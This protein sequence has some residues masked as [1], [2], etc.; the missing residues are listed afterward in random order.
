MLE[1][2][3]ILTVTSITWVGLLAIWAGASRRHWFLRAGVFVGVLSLLL[4]I[5]AYEPF[6]AFTLQGAVVAV[7]VK[8]HRWWVQRKEDKSALPRCL[9]YSVL[10]LLQLTVF[11]AI[12]M[13]VA[14]K[15]PVLNF[16][17][18]QSVVL[19]GLVSGSATLLGLWIAHGRLLRWWWRIALGVPLAILLS[20]PLVWWEWFVQQRLGIVGWPRVGAF[21]GLSGDGRQDYFTDWIPMIACVVGITS[22]V[23]WLLAGETAIGPKV[24]R[25]SGQIRSRPLRATACV[26]L[27]LVAILL[28]APPAYVY[29]RLMTPLPIPETVLPNPNGFDDLAAAGEMAQKWKYRDKADSY[30]VVPID[31]LTVAVKEMQP[32]FERLSIGL[33]RPVV[34]PV[35]YN[36]Y[37]YPA[38]ES[39]FNLRY[40]AKALDGQGRLAQREGRRD[41]ALKSFRDAIQLGY[42]FR[43]GGTFHEALTGVVISD[44]GRH[45]LY[46]LRGELATGQCVEVI[47][48]LNKYQEQTEPSEVIFYRTRV[49]WQHEREWY[50]YLYLI[51]EGMLNKPDR[52]PE[53]LHRVFTREIAKTQLL[54]TELAIQVWQMSHSTLPET[55]DDLVSNYLPEVPVDPFDPDGGPLRYRRT[56]DGYVLYSVSDNGKDDGG[57]P[58]DKDDDYWRIGKTGDLRLDILWAPEPEADEN[59][60]P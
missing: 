41:D 39:N 35:D 16:R 55:L 52:F 40:L 56:D 4:L 42:V 30:N 46:D 48:M 34:M 45:G 47:R 53:S 19:I 21:G 7:G 51:L 22:I 58:S 31:E 8:L 6:V 29:Y 28:T 3:S 60:E 5:P 59:D 38:Y 10:T 13:A 43:H 25:K 1:A 17:A 49:L 33:T 9:R 18:W 15:L 26:V 20:L 57:V 23:L 36:S 12:G 11:I 27:V 50:G 32:A 37:N 2:F 54:R 24:A 44:I 14:V